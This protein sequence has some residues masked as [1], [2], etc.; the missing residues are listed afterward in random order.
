MGVKS[1]DVV[2]EKDSLKPSN[3]IAGALGG[4]VVP[5]FQAINEIVLFVV[6]TYMFLL[7]VHDIA[8]YKRPTSDSGVG[9]S[10]AAGGSAPSA[11]T[12]SA[13]VFESQASTA[14]AF[15]FF[16]STLVYAIVAYLLSESET[17]KGH[18]RVIHVLGGIS[19]NVANISLLIAATAYSR[20]SNFDLKSALRWLVIFIVGAIFWATFWEILRH[21][22]NA[23]LTSVM[24]A[25]DV[26]VSNI[27][28]VFLG[29]A[30]FARW[31]GLGAFYLGLVLVY[32]LLQ[33]P[34]RIVLDLNKFVLPEHVGNLKPTFYLLA[35]GKI[36]LAWGFLVMLRKSTPD[37]I[38]TIDK[39][40]NWPDPPRKHLD[41][42]PVEIMHV[43][44]AFVFAIVAAGL[45]ELA[46]PH[47]Q[48]LH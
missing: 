40:K 7:W 2:A 43:V 38:T 18:D 15:W 31:S 25:P 21:E 32:A 9:T 12:K 44:L 17:E 33:F 13:L 10:S 42:T 3:D 4:Q 5:S 36:F 41:I 24:M 47:I 35:A 1:G 6:L 19:S 8:T 14:S 23:L 37:N 28:L 27:A 45:W 22:E 11:G 39:P 48:F 34:A 30:F 26:V 16:F 20:G 46:K 29:W